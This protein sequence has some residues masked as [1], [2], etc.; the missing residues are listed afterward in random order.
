MGFLQRVALV[1][2]SDTALRRRPPAAPTSGGEGASGEQIQALQD[3][4]GRMA[5]MATTIK[6]LEEQAKRLDEEAAGVAKSE[7]ASSD[8][9]EIAERAHMQVEVIDEMLEGIRALRAA[10]DQQR[11]EL[12]EAE[13]QLGHHREPAT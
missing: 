10:I 12:I 3:T 8:D 11:A 6:Q 1:L 13:Q 9:A 2:R 7:A 4:A 5:A